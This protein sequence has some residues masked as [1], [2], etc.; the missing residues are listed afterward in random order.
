ML[1]N[2]KS[3]ITVLIFILL[4]AGLGFYSKPILSLLNGEKEESITLAQDPVLGDNQAPIT[5]I[6]FSDFECPYCALHSKETFPQIKREYIDTGKVKVVFKNFP[7]PSHR[8]AQKAAEA[9]ECAFEQGK[10]W[11]YK[12]KLFENQENL[13]VKNLKQYARDLGLDSKEF[14]QCLQSGRFEKEVKQDYQEGQ[15]KSIKGTPT[16]FINS[17]VLFG[18]QPFSEFQK[19]FEENLNRN[20]QR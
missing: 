11:E 20:E 2:Q 3:L 15:E 10:F 9:G 17:E 7:L 6:E 16:F 18:A 13:S 5:M 19:I 1:K 12:E 4:G 14:N 8:K